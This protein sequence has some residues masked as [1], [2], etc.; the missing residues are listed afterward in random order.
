MRDHLGGGFYRYATDPGWQTPHF[1]KMLYDNALLAS[2]YLRAAKI[3]NREDYEIVA[4]D[5]LDFML[6]EMQS[7]QG[8]MVASFSAVDGSG[9]E[10][11][12]YLWETETLLGILSRDEYHLMKMLWGLEGTS[13]LEAG[14]LARVQMS[15]GEAASQLKMNAEIAQK[16]YQSAREKLLK[17]RASRKLPVDDKLLAAWNG[18]ALT[19]LVQGA[20]L[21]GGKKYQDAAQGVRDY[22][23][24]TLWNGNRL[25]RA[26][27]KGGELGQASLEDYAFA[28]QGLLVWSSLTDSADDFQL[29]ARWVSDGWRRFYDDSGWLLSDQTLL[30][31]GFGVAILDESPLPSPSSTLLKLSLQVAERSGDKMLKAR[32]KKA[33][34]AGHLQLKQAAF[35]YPTQVRVLMENRP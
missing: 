21:P 24:N 1:E 25:L 18:L 9:V 2:L 6:N 20:K 15:I 32:A 19:A 8:A 13:S 16:R 5:T 31:S 29:A 14:Y 4:R 34:A 33:L 12:Y 17:V 26:K 30:P 23:V 28:A 7:S 10:G 11:G 27:G 3:F 22:L 35:D